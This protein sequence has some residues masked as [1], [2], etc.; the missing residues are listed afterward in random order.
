M[1]N[2]GTLGR[3]VDG[4]PLQPAHS[5]DSP[6]A[7]AL[8]VEADEGDTGEGEAIFSKL[9]TDFAPV[10]VSDAELSAAMTTLWLNIPLRVSASCPPLYVGRRLALASAPLSGEA[11]QSDLAQ[12]YGRFC[13]R[14]GTPG[15]CLTLFEDGPRL[16]D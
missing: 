13:E 12:S 2:G 6:E 10:R 7:W 14:C 15:D 11:W 8:E 16:Q 3:R 1:R 5:E 9:P 4:V